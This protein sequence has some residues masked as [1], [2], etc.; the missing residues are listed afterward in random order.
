M[1]GSTMN[2]KNGKGVIIEYNFN[3]LVKKEFKY[4]KLPLNDITEVMKDYGIEVSLLIN[5]ISD[6]KRVLLNI[7]PNFE[8][9]DKT[10]LGGGHP[11]YILKKDNELLFIECKQNNDG[12]RINQLD[13]AFENIQQ[14]KQ[15]RILSFSETQISGE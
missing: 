6:W 8:I 4:F 13:W 11:D 14:G 2:G 7:Y 3:E 10:K 15:V 1:A 5:R 9:D 12:L